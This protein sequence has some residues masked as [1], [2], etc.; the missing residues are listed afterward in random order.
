MLERDDVLTPDFFQCIYIR[1]SESNSVFGTA[2]HSTMDLCGRAV[3]VRY[4]PTSKDDEVL[5]SGP[6]FISNQG[7]HEV[8]RVYDDTYGAFIASLIP[9]EGVPY[10]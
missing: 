8:W 6:Y 5:H 2:T 3:E 10:W 9:T 4:M 1:C 7:L